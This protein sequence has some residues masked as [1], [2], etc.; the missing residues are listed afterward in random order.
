M[1]KGEQ[2][3]NKISDE[4]LKQMMCELLDTGERGATN[5]YELLRTK[6]QLSKERCLQMYP[7]VESEWVK[8]KDNIVSVEREA[9]II[10][11]AKNGLKSKFEKQ[12]HIQKQIDEI[13]ADIDRGILEEYAV[14]SG[15]WEMVQKVMNAESKAYLRKTIK[16]LY[17]EL[18]K[19][20]GDYSPTK[21][22]NTDGSGNDISPI[23][24][25]QVV[26]PIED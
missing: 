4:V 18:N 22:A 6:V 2:K 21:I 5:F 17:A 26:N 15:Q 20:C 7:I 23:I 8:F 10:E 3:R 19:M 11:A 12:L 16:E 24:N 1:G 13:Q 9:T 25:I 14:I